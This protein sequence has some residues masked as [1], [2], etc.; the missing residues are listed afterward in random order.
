MGIKETI[1]QRIKAEITLD[2]QGV[3]YAGKTDAEIYNLLISPVVKKTTVDEVYPQPML[4]VINAIAE[5]PNT[6][7]L[8]DVTDALKP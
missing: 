8:S 5:G 1:M 6:I 2:P 3:G 4:R 7:S